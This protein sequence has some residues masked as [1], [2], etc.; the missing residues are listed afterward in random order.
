MCEL[1]F[2]SQKQKSKSKSETDP[3]DVATPYIEDFL[4][5]R[6]GPAINK[7]GGATPA[8]T[9][10]AAQIKANAGMAAPYAAGADALAKDLFGT[11]SRAPQVE[12]AFSE[13]SSRLNPVA[14]GANLSLEN[15]PYISAMLSKTAGDAMTRANEMFAGA[16]RSFSGAH[17]G[18]IGRAVT[19]AQLPTLANLYQYEQGRTDSA[20][21]DLMTQASGAATTEANLDQVAANLRAMGIDVGR[22]AVD[23][24]NL[25]PN[26][27]LEIEQQMKLLPYDEMAKLAAILFPAGN[28]GQQSTGSSRSKS[29]GFK[30]DSS[31]AK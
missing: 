14:S 28:L 11:Q 8:Q 10:A 29:S 19:E 5:S 18:E 22:G 2:G 9:Q 16:G 27:I 20:T 15:N 17:V 12:Q 30:I 7:T 31:L 23:L 26:Q 3:W 25:G 13:F 4:S 6:V 21:R 24:K 1:G